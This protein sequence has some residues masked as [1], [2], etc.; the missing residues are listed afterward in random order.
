MTFIHF[1]NICFIFIIYLA[2]LVLAAICGS[3]AV[4]C[5]NLSSPVGIEPGQLAFG[6]QS[7]SH[8]TTREVP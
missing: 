5:G 4:A 8:W 7:L 6:A 2:V 1:L 3:S